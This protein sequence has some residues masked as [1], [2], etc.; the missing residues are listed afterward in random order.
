MDQISE[1]V[2]A[3][4]PIKWNDLPSYIRDEVMQCPEHERFV[5]V[6]HF[7]PGTVAREFRANSSDIVM[8][9]YAGDHTLCMEVFENARSNEPINRFARTAMDE[10]LCEHFAAAI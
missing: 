6:L 10:S 3:V 4:S 9:H 5:R 1:F 8:R 7:L 2:A